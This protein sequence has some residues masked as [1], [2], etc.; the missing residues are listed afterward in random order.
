MPRV[1]FTFRHVKVV[2]PLRQKTSFTPMRVFIFVTILELF[3][4]ENVQLQA[5]KRKF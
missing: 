4:N 5:T 2:K 1:Q 3:M